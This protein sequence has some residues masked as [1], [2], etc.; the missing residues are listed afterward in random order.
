MLLVAIE[1]GNKLV[2]GCCEHA[3]RAGVRVGMTL[4][5]ARSLL[6]DRQVCVEPFAPEQDA[7]ALEHLARWALRFT[8]VATPDPPDGL[9]LDI[10]GCDRLYGGEA[11]LAELLAVSIERLGFAVRAAVGPTFAGARAVARH[12]GNRMKIL[13][14]E[15]I[16]EALAALPIT[17]LRIDPIIGD[18]LGEIGVERIGQL[19]ALP[20]D[21]LVARFGSELLQRLDEAT[22]AAPE[23][24]EPI[25]P[26][27]K[28]EALRTFDGPVTCPEV[29]EIAA[30]ELLTAL[31]TQLQSEQQGVSRLTVELER[32]DL[33]PARLALS[34]TH[35]T[36]DRAHLWSLL[37]PR[38]ER[39]NLGYGV[40]E[41][42][43]LAD[44][45]E[46][47]AHEQLALWAQDSVAQ[48]HSTDAALGQ[49]LDQL[50]ERLGRDAVARVIPVECY[51]PERAFASVSFGLVHSLESSRQGREGGVGVYP[52]HRPSRLLESPEPIRVMAIVPEGP[53]VWVEW[54]GT[55]G[56]VLA[57][58]GPERIASPWW[59]RGPEE[60]EDGV[61]DYFE[62]EDEGGRWLWVF[63]NTASNSWFV[64]GEWA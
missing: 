24:I 32:G 7:K 63:R 50:I 6:T 11:R 34:L 56:R 33:G 3:E 9:F 39:I 51:L 52:A 15:E 4:A 31:M 26:Q 45:A 43:L 21:G 29:I 38:L 30:R 64:H 2:A 36:Q 40:E 22:G 19:R 59:T 10:A 53:P 44:R 42:R 57:C 62:V 46:R 18:A 13:R 60:S 25:R 17:A 47:M 5:H 58:Y 54:K 48:D 23:L 55:G 14:A 41:I 35:P 12:A 37:R 28:Q 8:P 61:R 1:R 49:L 20:R 27:R 16:E